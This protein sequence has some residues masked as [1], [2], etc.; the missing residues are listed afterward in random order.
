MKENICKIRNK[1]QQFL[2]K[3][4]VYCKWMKEWTQQ[5]VNYL[6]EYLMNLFIIF[7]YFYKLIHL[8]GIFLLA[9]RTWQK[10]NLSQGSFG[11]NFD[12]PTAIKFCIKVISAFS[13]YNQQDATFLNLF[14]SI[15]LSACFRRFLRQ[16]SGAQNSTY[17]VRHLSD[18]YCYLL[19]AAG[20]NNGLTNAWRSMCCF[21]LL[22]ID[23][24]TVWNMQRVL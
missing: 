6:I 2:C 11:Q 21:E 10:E 24:K 18:R 12:S 17:S 19:L 8:K 23:G 15:R 1:I 14:I 20:S 3:Y 5:R 9:H 22:M 13:D 4:S 16:S 7:W